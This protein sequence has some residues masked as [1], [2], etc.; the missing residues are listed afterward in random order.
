MATTTERP[1]RGPSTV[2]RAGDPRT[3]KIARLGKAAS[4][5]SRAPYKTTAIRTLRL[6]MMRDLAAGKKPRR[7]R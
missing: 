3:V 6:Q 4:P 1:R 2:F 5:W 7:I